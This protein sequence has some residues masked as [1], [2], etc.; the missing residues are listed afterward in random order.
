MDSNSVDIHAEKAAKIK[1][2][3]AQE[4]KLKELQADLEKLNAKVEN[5]E[6]L[7][8]EDTKFISNLGWI[9][10][11]SITIATIADSIM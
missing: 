11:L 3:Q 8:E 2:L 10:A 1:E 9:T 5:K 6:P 7:S 4:E